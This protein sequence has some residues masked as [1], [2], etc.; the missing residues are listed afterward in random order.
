MINEEENVRV[1]DAVAE[2]IEE[3]RS[4]LSIASNPPSQCPILNIIPSRTSPLVEL[5]ERAVTGREPRVV[6]EALSL[7]SFDGPKGTV[8]PVASARSNGN[9]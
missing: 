3:T 8:S 6:Y 9:K 5:V 7:L 2:V 1:N 4:V